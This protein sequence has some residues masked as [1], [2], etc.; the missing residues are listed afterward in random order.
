MSI[1]VDLRHGSRTAAKRLGAGGPS[2]G[3]GPSPWPGRKAFG[4][5][6]DG[7][8]LAWELGESCGCG[9]IN[10]FLRLKTTLRAFAMPSFQFLVK[11][12]KSMLTALISRIRYVSF[13]QTLNISAR[14]QEIITFHQL[15]V[16]SDRMSLLIVHAIQP[17][18]TVS[19]FSKER[20]GIQLEVIKSSKSN[21]HL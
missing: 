19:I 12:G 2:P 18:S 20:C 9:Q 4:L 11:S 5:R 17:L 8:G 1:M 15:A 6:R 3:G 21:E 14:N 13:F 7:G 10:H 16:F